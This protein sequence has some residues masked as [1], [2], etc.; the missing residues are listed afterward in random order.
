MHESVKL[1]APSEVEHSRLLYVLAVA[2]VLSAANL[3]YNQPV[4]ADMARTFG[5][6]EAAAGAVPTLTQV[7]YA[8]G[9]LLIVPLGDLFSRR[10]LIGTLLVLVALALVATAAAPTLT[11][12]SAASLFVGVTTCIPQLI[13]PLAATLVPR[14]RRGRAV[15]IIM[16]GL[17]L[18]LLLS[19]TA[20]GTVAHYLG[21]RAIYWMAAGAML[22]MALVLT[23]ILPHAR[24]TRNGERR[25]RYPQLLRSVGVLVLREPVLRQAMLNGALLFAAFSAFWATLAFRLE[26]SPLHYGAQVAGLFGLVG[27]AGALAAPLVG[28]LADHVPPRTILTYAAAGELISFLVFWGT[29]HTIAGLVVGVLLL[30]LAVQA[31]QVSN[32]TRVYT[33]SADAHSRVNS[34]FMVSYFAGGAAGS[35][36]ATQAW[37][38][39]GWTGVCALGTALAAAALV[40]HVLVRRPDT[41]M[42]I[43]PNAA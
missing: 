9:M 27:A 24:V 22:L 31:A 41:S 13:L 18:G 38:A 37:Q 4:L 14:E 19:R 3:C 30:D 28:R 5:V 26:T 12:L 23:P 17:L 34:A 35:F 20:A 1:D 25:P 42:E 40:T 10:W 33:I 11:A 36:L 6:S 7:G 21:W 43:A 2:A 29:G 39:A 32:M 15:G 16:M 8:L